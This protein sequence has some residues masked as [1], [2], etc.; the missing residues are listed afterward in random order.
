M[1][2]KSHFLIFAVLISLLAG[3]QPV[4]SSGVSPLQIEL[5]MKPDILRIKENVEFTVAVTQGKEKIDT[6]TEVECKIT[7]NGSDKVESISGV[8]KGNGLYACKKVFNEKGTY[9]VKV[10]VTANDL[11]EVDKEIVEVHD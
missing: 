3:C 8:S 4:Q 2:R 1:E 6:V 5:Q 11:L 9:T 7:K 10:F